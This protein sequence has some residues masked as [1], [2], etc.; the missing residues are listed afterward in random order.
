MMDQISSPI[1]PVCCSALY[2]MLIIIFGWSAAVI[3][4]VD[5]VMPQ[6]VLQGNRNKL[7]RLLFLSKVS[8]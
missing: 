6:I 3:R 4:L 7:K 8:V 5:C 2:T 1:H